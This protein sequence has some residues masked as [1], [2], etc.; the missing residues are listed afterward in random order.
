MRRN[1]ENE[2]HDT[3]SSGQQSDGTQSGTPSKSRKD[4]IYGETSDGD[5]SS[6]KDRADDKSGKHPE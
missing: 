6:D 2:E 5:K 3:A 4:L 1:D